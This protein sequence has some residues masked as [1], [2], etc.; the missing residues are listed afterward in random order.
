MMPQT[1]VN[2]T[3]RPM[4]NGRV[5]SSPAISPMGERQ[6]IAMSWAGLALAFLVVMAGI[7]LGASVVF[8][9]GFTGWLIGM[10]VMALVVAIL[11]VAVSILMRG[12]KG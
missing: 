12:S 11:A 8:D 4:A 9:M 2:E 1:H 7:S 10:G 5:P 6:T 3:E